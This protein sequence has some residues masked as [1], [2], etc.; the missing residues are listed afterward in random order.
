MSQ[1]MSEFFAI[2][3][4]HSCNSRLGI[5]GF[6]IAMALEPHWPDR[7]K[8]PHHMMRPLWA[9]IAQHSNLNGRMERK[10]PTHRGTSVG[11]EGLE[12]PTTS[13]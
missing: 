10:S 13:V 9:L 3:L 5:P 2:D 8:K 11:A 6:A 7:N 12:P 1:Q 4:R